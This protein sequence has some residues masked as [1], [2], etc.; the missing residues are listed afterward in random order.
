[1]TVSAGIPGGL[2]QKGCILLSEEPDC[3]E[4]RIG[5]GLTQ[6]AETRFFHHH[7]KLLQQREIVCRSFAVRDLL[8]EVMN[9]L[10]PD[11]AGNTFT[12]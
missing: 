6:T 12:A 5:R 1:M 4:N 3:R 2:F 9:V 10:R 8:E 11:S 7:A